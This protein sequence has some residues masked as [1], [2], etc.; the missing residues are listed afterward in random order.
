MER[1]GDMSI[2]SYLE[3]GREIHRQR[4]DRGLTQ[5]ELAHVAGVSRRWLGLLES[6][7]P[8]AQLDK[9][10]ALLLAL[11]LKVDLIDAP[12][13]DNAALLAIVDNQEW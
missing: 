11:E 6:G 13:R 9:V 12:P 5:E 10:F 3:L 1:I 2:G 7:H 8:G 4:L